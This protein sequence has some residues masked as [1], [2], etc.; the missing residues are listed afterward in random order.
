M[1]SRGLVVAIAVVLAVLAAVGVIVYTSNVREN[2][3][4]ENTTPVIA[5]TQDIA[6]GT[7]LDPLIAANVFETINVAQDDVVPGAVVDIT[8]LEGQTTAAPIYQNEQ[9][10]TARLANG[11]SNNLGISEGNLG[12]GLAVD[13]PAAVNGFIQQ[14]DHVAVLATFPAG[15]LVTRQDLKFYL[16]GA[17]LKS[18]ISQL[19]GT[20]TSTNPNVF[21]MPADFTITLI[22]A[23]KV[24]SVTNP[25]T[26]ANTGKPAS[27]S[28]TFVMDLSPSDATSLVWAVTH[29]TLY[30]G[31]LPP[32]NDKGYGQPGVIGAPLAR[33]V[34]VGTP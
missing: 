26:D 7:Q 23:A 11:T 31:L 5:S 3:V 10:P 29:S 15:T 6:S 27:G 8:Q 19:T 30:L 17:Q 13:G 21:V 2:A 22:P 1:R 32:D 9:I 25:A 18:L 16:A 20:T 28:S 12:I 14:G 34:G 4:N 33:V 24:L